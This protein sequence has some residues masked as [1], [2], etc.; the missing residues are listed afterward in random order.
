MKCIMPCSLL[1][2][3]MFVIATGCGY[4]EVGPQAYEYSKALYSITNRQAEDKLE[5]VAAQ[6]AHAAEQGE[7]SGAE[8]DVLQAIIDKAADGNWKAAN[9]DTRALMEAQVK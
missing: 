4:G 7:L 5:D 6:I 2:T 3:A 1:L 9:R 8:A